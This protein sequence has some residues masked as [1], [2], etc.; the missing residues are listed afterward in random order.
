M[1]RVYK[2]LFILTAI[3]GF[4]ASCREFKKMRKFSKELFSDDTHEAKV[5]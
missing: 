3:A 4:I 5:Q 2:T 1:K